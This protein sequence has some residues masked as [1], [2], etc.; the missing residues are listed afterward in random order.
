VTV[1]KN[2]DITDTLGKSY[3]ALY[4]DEKYYVSKENAVDFKTGFYVEK[5]NA[6]DFLEEKLTYIGLNDKERDEF[7]MYWLPIL[8]NN[9]KSLVYFELTDEREQNNKLNITPQP[10]SMLRVIIHVKKVDKKVKIKEQILVP[11]TRYGFTAV[12]WGG[13]N[14]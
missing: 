13:V 11:F 14:H 3:Y 7:I 9:E 4:W 12:E 2:G 5:E 6:I 1:N 8:E 10:D